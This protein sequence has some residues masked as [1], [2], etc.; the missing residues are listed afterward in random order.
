MLLNISLGAENQLIQQSRYTDSVETLI[1]K[2]VNI[3]V[4]GVSSYIVLEWNGT[5]KQL[6]NKSAREWHNLERCICE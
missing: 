6:Y 2:G 5:E 1:F 3:S 4:S